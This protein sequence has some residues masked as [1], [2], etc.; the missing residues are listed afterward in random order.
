MNKLWML[1]KSNMR[2]GKSAVVSLFL[3]IFVAAI[4]LNVGCL[5]IINYKKSFDKTADKLNSAHT[6][7]LMLKS[8]YQDTYEEYY[9]NY[10]DV[11][12]VQKEDIIYFTS[13]NFKF[14]SGEMATSLF[15]R[16][17]DK[18]S[19]LSGISF[20]GKHES[21]DNDDIYVSYLMKSGGGY[22]LGD[23]LVINYF[24]KEYTFKIAG[25]VEDIMYG[26]T[27]SGCSGFYLPE[28]SY[29]NLLDQL[30]TPEKAEGILLQS[31]LKSSLNANNLINDFQKNMLTYNQGSQIPGY[32]FESMPNIKSARTLTADIGGAIIVCFSFIII[33]VSLLVIRFRINTSIEEGMT[34]IGAL[35]AIGYSSKQIKA[36][37]LLQFLSVAA[38]GSFLGIA[39]SY[40]FVKPL[41]AMF[42]AQTGLIWKQGFDFIASLISLGFIL[43]SVL[44]ITAAST[45][46]IKRLH[47][48]VALR[49]GIHTHSFKKNHFS[50][51]RGRG[52]L[53]FLLAMK[54]MRMNI[55]QNIMITIIIVA[56]S[57]SSVFAI[58]LY[59]NIVKDDKAFIN[60]LGVEMCS[61]YVNT[62]PSI[63]AEVLLG[64]IR[65]MEEVRKAVNYEYK[66]LMIGSEEV[67]VY[68]MK[69]FSML[70]SDLAYDGRYPEYD[71]EVI[72]TGFVAEEF[73]KKVG[74]M[75][76][77]QSGD[78]SADFL[79]SGL[80]ESS[81]N[82]GMG[83]AVTDTGMKRLQPDYQFGG[84]NIYLKKGLNAE[85]FTQKLLIKFPDEIAGTMNMD[86]M[87]KS[88][89]GVYQSIVAIFAYFILIITALIVIMILYLVIKAFIIR[90]RKDYG[91]QKAIGYTTSQLMTQ[92]SFSF[93]PVI[94]F[95]TVIGSIL[96]G[97]YVNSILTLLFRAIGVMNVNFIVPVLWIVFLCFG[98]GLLAY[99][100]SMLISLRIRN[101]SAHA[102]MIDL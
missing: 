23:K 43:L 35:K 48:I 75:I 55:K 102:L 63:D 10:P 27:N 31:K 24:D 13:A 14:G 49:N 92:T 21:E 34:D 42:S 15:F 50:L 38:G 101:I 98:I 22:K 4:L 30:E 1:A 89:L 40:L 41:A 46:R 94:L 77:I 85:E 69:D 97:M 99:L 20:V 37:T 67:Q 54:S 95:G 56:V 84:I 62:M 59:Y 11:L 28:A 5:T 81:N 76:T 65:D 73:H 36:A 16:N 7:M 78:K 26:S 6:A 88:Q 53:N 83:I 52:S 72:I 3:V 64:D 47:P 9:S 8:S 18:I 57:F 100:I 39:A 29:R 17:I 71:N 60:M 68:I 66:K 80:F 58:I 45:G 82:F 70:E 74:D 93:L 79:I 32:W 12:Q 51:D 61:V 33:L 2:K 87:T 91:I 19:E 25:F 44:L 90:R 86:M 96:G